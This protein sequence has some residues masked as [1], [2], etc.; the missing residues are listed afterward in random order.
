VQASLHHFVKLRQR[1]EMITG[2]GQRIFVELE[3]P[4][5]Q[6]MSGIDDLFSKL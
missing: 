3:K 5:L 1:L 6:S 4:P 2:V